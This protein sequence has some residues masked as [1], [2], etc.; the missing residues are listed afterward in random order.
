MDFKKFLSRKIFKNGFNKFDLCSIVEI[1]IIAQRRWE[2]CFWNKILLK[3]KE[4]LI[5]VNM[6]KGITLWLDKCGLFFAQ[7]VSALN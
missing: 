5:W 4:K 2:L 1:K 3:V 6:L 7:I